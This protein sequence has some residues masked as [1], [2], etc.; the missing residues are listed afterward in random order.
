MRSIINIL[1]NDATLVALLG[2][3][4]QIGMNIIEQGKKTPYVVVDVED[5]QPTNTFR[6]ASDL[7]FVHFTVFSVA[8][9]PFTNGAVVG[10]DEVGKAVRTALDYVA[11]GTYDGEV[12]TRCTFERGGRIQE[13]RIANKMQ[14]TRE[15]EYLLSVRP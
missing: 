14:I 10:A 6:E 7:D 9:R 11:A 3:A 12:I 15:D 5:S 2:N 8:D 1:Q 13:D 4:N